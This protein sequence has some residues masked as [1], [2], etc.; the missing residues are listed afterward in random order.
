MDLGAPLLV[1][2][3]VTFVVMLV[4]GLQLAA[5]R[6][7]WRRAGS[8]STGSYREA[9]RQL[10]GAVAIRWDVVGTAA[11]ASAWSIATVLFVG[12]GALLFLIVSSQSQGPFLLGL[13]L[14]LLSGLGL[15]GSNLRAASRLV[16][17][18]PRARTSARLAAFHGYA[19]HAYVLVVFFAWLVVV[20]P[21]SLEE[22]LLAITPLC[23]FGAIVAALLHWASARVEGGPNASWTSDPEPRAPLT[24]G[25]IGAR[26]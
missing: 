9:P 4:L 19:H 2:G 17:R 5:H 10:P 7:R 24:A 12:A 16:R 11:L 26:A 14:A 23:G 13:G 8:T 21:G 15:V 18:H 25:A 20:E 3:S 6:H 22:D 1:L